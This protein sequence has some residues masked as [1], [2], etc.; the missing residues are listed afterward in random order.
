ML[1]EIDVNEHKNW[2][3][4]SFYKKCRKEAMVTFLEKH[5]TPSPEVKKLNKI[6][7]SAEVLRVMKAFH[8]A[9]TTKDDGSNIDR[10]TGGPY[11]HIVTSTTLT[12]QAPLGADK[13]AARDSVYPDPTAQDNPGPYYPTS[14]SGRGFADGCQKDLT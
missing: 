10:S 4:M 5:S 13:Q 6:D 9:N 8:Q 12:P 3:A 1:T 11:S 7:M 14:Y 2:T